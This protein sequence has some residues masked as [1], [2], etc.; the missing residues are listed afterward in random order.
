MAKKKKNRDDAKPKKGRRQRAAAA[1]VAP[2]LRSLAVLAAKAGDDR[3]TLAG[4]LAAYD[5]PVQHGAVDVRRVAE[6][7]GRSARGRAAREL[8]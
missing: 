6:V 5:I 7:F 1:D 8:T 2:C 3:A 4:A